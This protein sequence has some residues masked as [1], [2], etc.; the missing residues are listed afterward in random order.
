MECFGGVGDRK[1][2]WVG[3]IGCDCESDYELF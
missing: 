2:G 3:L 1:N